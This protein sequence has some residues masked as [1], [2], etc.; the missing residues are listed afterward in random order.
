M[1]LSGKALCLKTMAHSNVP[2]ILFSIIS[3]DGK[4]ISTRIESFNFNKRENERTYDKVSHVKSAKKL[5]WL[6]S[7][8]DIIQTSSNFFKIIFQIRSNCTCPKPHRIAGFSP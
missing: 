7:F 5:G 3:K 8:I 2:R 6:V 4:F 1:A